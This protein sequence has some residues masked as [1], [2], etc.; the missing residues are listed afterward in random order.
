[1]KN[2]RLTDH[3]ITIAMNVPCVVSRCQSVPSRDHPSGRS[4]ER[5]DRGCSEDSKA[6]NTIS[7]RV[8]IAPNVTEINTIQERDLLENEQEQTRA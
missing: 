2:Y 3:R 5:P 7:K 8:T 6:T 1:M 4:Y